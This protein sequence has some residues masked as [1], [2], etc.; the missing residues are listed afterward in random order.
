[1]GWAERPDFRC[2]G[3]TERGVD[4]VVKPATDWAVERDSIF[5]VFVNAF[6]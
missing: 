6:W 5:A 1:M 2:F 3:G 4:E